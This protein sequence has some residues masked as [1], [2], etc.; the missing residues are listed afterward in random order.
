MSIVLTGYWYA[1]GETF[2]VYMAGLD[3]GDYV[4]AADGTITVPYQSDPDEALTAA[5]LQE[6]SLEGGFNE[7][8]TTISVTIGGIPT[9]VQIPLVVG[10]NYQSRGQLVRP[11]Q[12]SEAKAVR[13]PTLGEKRRI[14]SFAA[15]I[16]I[17]QMLE[18]GTSSA[19]LRPSRF[20]SGNQLDP[21]AARVGFTGVWQDTIDSTTDYDNM[22]WWNTTRP[23]PA[24]ISA[25]EGFMDTAER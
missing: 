21:L 10:A 13:G 4:V 5:Y 3:C 1:V 7:F 17:A 18:F 19:N 6:I 14:S 20:T 8:Y 25:I 2:S 23:Y 24:T 9:D 16:P 22:I 12:Q 11:N 15:L